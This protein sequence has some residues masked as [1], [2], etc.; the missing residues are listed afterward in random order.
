MHHWP[1]KQNQ[2]A[3]LVPRP[4]TLSKAIPSIGRFSEPWFVRLV[5]FAFSTADC[6]HGNFPD[7]AAAFC[8]AA[9]AEEPSVE[10][11]FQLFAS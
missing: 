8:V 4:H 6:D 3:G 2:R 5:S 9:I 1:L 7:A 11:L 10:N